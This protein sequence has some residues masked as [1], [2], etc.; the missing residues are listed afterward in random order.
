M[1]IVTTLNNSEKQAKKIATAI[2]AKY[3]KTLVDKF[4]DEE[5]YIKY[6]TDLKGK[7]LIIVESL[8]PNPNKSL[9]NVIFAA[10]A[11]KMQG[12][13]KVILIAPYLGFMRQD[14]MFNPGEAV[15]AQIMAD[16]MNTYIDKLL[17]IDPHLH[18]ILKMKDVFTINAKNLTANSA[19]GDFIKKKYSKKD[20]LIMGPDGES[21][22]WADEIAKQV[23]VKDTVLHKDR[24][25]GRNVDVNLTETVD[26]K[27]K[28]I[29]IVDD[30]ISTGNTMIKAAIKSKKLGAKTITAIGVHGLFVENGL[31]KMKKHF[32]N[33]YTV[34]TIEH[35]TNKID[36][37]PVIIEELSK[38]I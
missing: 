14:K 35:E 20:L 21:Y 23:G 25:T 10:K 28:H 18:R 2:N 17:T 27:G 5:I 37:T 1:V 6:N 32:D 31:N 15:N 29:V 7:K 19:I 12:A 9:L 30:I 13:K 34:N 11:A 3:S 26:L 36:I 24:H 16:L 38:R 22:Q 4:P 8:Q 33:I